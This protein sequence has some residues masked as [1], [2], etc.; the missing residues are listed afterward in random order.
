M[1]LFFNML[2]P[3]VKR[4][5]GLRFFVAALTLAV[6]F[7]LRNFLDPWLRWHSPFALLLPA[8]LI[9]AW[10]GGARAG[11]L[12]TAVAGFVAV[13][14]FM[15]PAGLPLRNASDAVAFLLF[16][17]EGILVSGLCAVLHHAVNRAQEA[18]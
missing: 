6:A 8:V 7:G 1:A 10:Y 18:A 12:A 5:G 4:S 2:R 11:L 17:T 16:I 9:S 3:P 13:S 14:V 15:V